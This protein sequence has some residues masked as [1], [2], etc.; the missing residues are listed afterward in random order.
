[1]STVSLVLIPLVAVLHAHHVQW[2]MHAPTLTRRCRLSVSLVPSP[3][4]CSHSALSVHPD[5]KLGAINK[6][7]LHLPVPIDAVVVHSLVLHPW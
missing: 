1:M 7:Q 3:L 4:E 2:A 6:L 5:C